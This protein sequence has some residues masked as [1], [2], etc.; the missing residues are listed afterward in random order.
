MKKT[1]VVIGS[2]LILVLIGGLALSGQTDYTLTI[3]NK[4]KNT[5]VIK[6][7]DNCSSLTH[8]NNT[9]FPGGTKKFRYLKWKCNWTAGTGKF[10]RIETVLYRF[11]SEFTNTQ[12][13]IR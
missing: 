5:L 12:W 11:T 2:V 3:E 7:Q 1:M 6:G 10:G 9:I 8:M 4:T 13:V